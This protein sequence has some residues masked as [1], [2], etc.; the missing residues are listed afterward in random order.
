MFLR[1]L[2]IRFANFSAFA[3]DS[4]NSQN[5]HASGCETDSVSALTTQIKVSSQGDRRQVS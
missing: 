3:A 4:F 2:R 1:S 5:I